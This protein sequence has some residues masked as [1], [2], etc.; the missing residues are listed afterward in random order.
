[1]PLT[2]LSSQSVFGSFEARF[3]CAGNIMRRLIT[4]RWSWLDAILVGLIVSL[5]GFGWW[6]NVWSRD[7][8]FVYQCMSDECH[9]VWQELQF[10]RIAAGNDVDEVI[11]RTNPSIVER[12]GNTV[13]LTYYL[14]F[15]SHSDTV[16]LTG[17]LIEARRGKLVAAY[18]WSCNWARQFF[19]EVGMED[20][21]FAFSHRRLPQGGAIWGPYGY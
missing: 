13:R 6:H 14:N 7:E 15:A 16:H 21:F 17:I 3:F 1:L 9:P 11:A 12:D 20:N 2:D 8:W 4:R 10:G 18:A 19:D 5:L